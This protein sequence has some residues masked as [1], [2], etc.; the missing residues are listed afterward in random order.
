MDYNKIIIVLAIILLIVAAG[1]L[2][3]V[4]NSGS[5]NAPAVNNSTANASQNISVEQVNTEEVA[6]SDSSGSSRSSTHVII[7]E[8]GCYYR[9]DDSGNILES[10]GPS[11]KYYP[12]G[13]GGKDPVSYPNAEPAN[14][15]I[16][17]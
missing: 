13:Y 5:N 11:K 1:G 7:G 4:L 15:Y 12:N 8:D 3:F 10:L 17:K 2:L 9:V 6:S 14:R 16:K